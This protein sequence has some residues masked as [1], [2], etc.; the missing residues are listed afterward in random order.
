MVVCTDDDDGALVVVLMVV[1][2]NEQVSRRTGRLD[3]ARGGSG[4]RGYGVARGQE[5]GSRRD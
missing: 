5:G 3:D 1:E 4:S 2:A